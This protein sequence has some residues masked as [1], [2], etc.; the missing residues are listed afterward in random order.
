MHSV[1]RG[2]SACGLCVSVLVALGGVFGAA[3]AGADGL[4]L[5]TNDWFDASFTALTAD[6]PIAQGGTT[7]ITRGA[8]SWTAVPS[9]GTAKIVE[10]A[11]NNSA[12]VLSVEAPE[13]ELEFTP[14]AFASPTGMETVTFKVK[15]D[16]IATLPTPSD[17]QTAFTLY[18][19]DG[20]NYALMG[21]VSDG[22]G[23]VWTN[24]TGVT[25]SAIVNTWFDLTLDFSGA[26]SSRVVRF[27]VN[28]T[29][30]A[31]SDGATWF[32]VVKQT[33]TTINSLSFSGVGDVKTFNGVLLFPWRK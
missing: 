8:G 20:A 11:D 10:D 1:K 16:A 19:A 30:L 22:A 27:A 33:A 32:P 21:Y 28:G 25:A 12:T 9:S 29:M 13:E 14:A 18:S 7:G 15:A 17:A 23:A 6:T 2:V 3:A 4:N 5:T 24:L 31:D 26:N